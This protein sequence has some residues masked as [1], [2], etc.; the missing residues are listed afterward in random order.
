MRLIKKAAV[1]LLAASMVISGGI[2]V[3]ASVKKSNTQNSINIL[4]QSN[5]NNQISKVGQAGLSGVKKAS[6]DDLVTLFDSGIQVAEGEYINVDEYFSVPYST[7]V[8]FL[9]LAD[10]KVEAYCDIIDLSTNLS[11]QYTYIPSN[12]GWE[13]DSNG[14]GGYVYLFYVPLAGGDYK[15]NLSI[16]SDNIGIYGIAGMILNNSDSLP[17]VT[18]NPDNPSIP[19]YTPAPGTGTGTG[20]T[21]EPSSSSTPGTGTGTEI[22]V[23]IATTPPTDYSQ[24]YISNV[25]MVI[26]KGFSGVLKTTGGGKVTWKS[27]NNKVAVVSSSGKVSAKSTGKA[28][29]VATASDGRQVY[30]TVTV[31]ANEYKG[32]KLTGSDMVN[33][34]VYI[35][36]YSM[37]YDKKG[38]LIVKA[39][40]VNNSSNQVRKLKNIN[41]STYTNKGKQLAVCNVKSKSVS[42]KPWKRTSITFKINKSE[43]KVKSRQDLRLATVGGGTFL[44]L[45]K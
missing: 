21:H 25:D 8:G 19:S 45:Y 33:T 7:T 24:F 36:P 9:L 20:V 22:P 37:K 43:L 3:D 5:S 13:Y 28:D 32:K 40:F 17:V 41:F 18:P 30:C 31:K 44:Y 2:G 35:N 14:S 11:M 1:S 16:P 39:E 23:P 12:T 15:I 4:T 29:I 27:K 34:G 42:I 10:K 38:N 26:T 6:A